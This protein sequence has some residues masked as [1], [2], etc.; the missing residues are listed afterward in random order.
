MADEDQKTQNQDGE[1]K[2]SSSNQLNSAGA[3]IIIGALMGLITGYLLF[4][5]ASV[6]G[7]VF[8]ILATLLVIFSAVQIVAG[9]RV[10]RRVGRRLAAWLLIASPVLLLLAVFKEP[11]AAILGIALDAFAILALRQSAG[12]F[13]RRDDE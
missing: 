8:A 13:E 4:G 7:V 9:I 6:S 11:L 10:F 12:Q 1:R 3:L 2:K 5:I